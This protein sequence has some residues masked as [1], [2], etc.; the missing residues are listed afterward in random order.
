MRSECQSRNLEIMEIASQRA[1]L[2]RKERAN[3]LY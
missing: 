3:L 1:R 2:H